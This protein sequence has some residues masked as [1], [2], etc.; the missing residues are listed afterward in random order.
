MQKFI[1]RLTVFYY[2]FI[3]LQFFFRLFGDIIYMYVTTR[4]LFK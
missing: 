3:D 4:G 1:R 2:F